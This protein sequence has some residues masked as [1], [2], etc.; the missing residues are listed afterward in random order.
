MVPS[1]CGRVELSAPPRETFAGDLRGGTLCLG[2]LDDHSVALDVDA[3][4]CPLPQIEEALHIFRYVY[5][6]LPSALGDLPHEGE[7]WFIEPQAL[8]RPLHLGALGGVYEFV[9]VFWTPIPVHR[10]ASPRK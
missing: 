10:E 2:R 6:K 5:G 1:G 8:R 3:Y 4:C 7:L 9:A